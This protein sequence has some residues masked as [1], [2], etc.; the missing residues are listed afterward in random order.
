MTLRVACVVEGH[1]AGS[2]IMGVGVHSGVRDGVAVAG[3][4]G[5]SQIIGVE[6]GGGGGSQTIGPRQAAL[7]P[8]N[9]TTI[10]RIAF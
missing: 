2:Q 4:G 6:E 9:T 10:A 3:G 1:G 8:P 5:G 7:L